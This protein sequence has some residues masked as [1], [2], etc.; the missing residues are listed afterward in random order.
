VQIS[1][2]LISSLLGGA[3]VA[4]ISYL[5]TRNRTQAEARKL[6]A[7]T[8]QIKV[9]TERS[10]AETT[11]QLGAGQAVASLAPTG[12]MPRGWGLWGS[13]PE[14]YVVGTDSSI[15]HSGARSGF[16]ASLI[17]PRGFATL[18]QTFKAERFR[19]KRVRMSAYVKTADVEQWSGLWMRVDG[20]D[21]TTLAFDNMQDRP[22]S[23]TIDWRLYHVVLDIAKEAED[24]AFGILLSGPGRAWIDDVQFEVVSNEVAPTGS[25]P[26]PYVVPEAPINLDF[27][28]P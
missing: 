22:I 13:H 21:E 19:N 24:I 20:P 15:A 5:S 16:I 1:L 4:L 12:P 8:E 18:M 10:R 11:K 17:S 6:D 9:Q 23:G 27:D 3:V 14:D 28:L 26:E 7:E 25:R 2:G